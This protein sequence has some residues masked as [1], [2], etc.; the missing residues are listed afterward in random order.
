MIPP[1]IAQSIV[2]QWA[3]EPMPNGIVPPYFLIP[4]PINNL[5]NGPE[6]NEQLKIWTLWEVWDQV[7]QTLGVFLFRKEAEEYLIQLNAYNRFC[8]NCKL[9]LSIQEWCGAH[10][11]D[12]C[13]RCG[14]LV[15][16]CNV[17]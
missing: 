17:N 4:M 15:E 11:L 1:A 5:G 12:S 16:F 14:E 2:K 7:H 8:P 3:E 10:G 9:T 6:T 13:N